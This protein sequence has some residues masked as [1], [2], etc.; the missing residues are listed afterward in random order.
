[1]Q[2]KHANT[3]EAIAAMAD[4]AELNALRRQLRLKLTEHRYTYNFSWFSRPII[5]LPEDI[6]APRS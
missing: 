4:D 1:M 5:Q 3:T 2:V 6:V